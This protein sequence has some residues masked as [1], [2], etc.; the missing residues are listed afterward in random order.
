MLNFASVHS[1]SLTFTQTL[2]RLLAHPEYLEPLRQE[3]EA[4]VAEEGWTKAGMD[5]MHKIDSFVRETQRID[6]PIIF[7]LNRL[8]LAPFTFSN[9]VTIPAGTLFGL[10]VHSV[11]TDDELYPDAQEFD[12]FR[13]LKLRE[14]EGDDV[15]A[16]RHQTVTTSAEL[17]GFGLGRHSCPGRFLAANEVKALL[18]HILVT[19]NV[20]FEEGKGIPRELRIASFRAPRNANILFRKRQR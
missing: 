9:G 4:V 18:A 17:L 12:G 11:H 3:V 2:Y 6:G 20:K 14:K 13:F 5:K 15:L 8:A 7:G 16:A 10:P 1:T 19:Y